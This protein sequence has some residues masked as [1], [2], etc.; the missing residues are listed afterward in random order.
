MIKSNKAVTR[1]TRKHYFFYR[2]PRKLKIAKQIFKKLFE[3]KYIE[4]FHFSQ[5]SHRAETRKVASYR[6]NKNI[7]VSF[8]IGLI[9]SKIFLRTSLRFHSALANFELEI[10][11]VV[12]QFAAENISLLS[13][14]LV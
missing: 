10:H 11:L 5:G 9:E 7:G 12:E 13:G 2:K 3:K 1:K 6:K 4:V 8:K 14:R